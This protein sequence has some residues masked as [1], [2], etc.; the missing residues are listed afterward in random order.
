MKNI[1]ASFK[2]VTDKD[3]ENFKESSCLLTISVGQ[4]YHEGERFAATVE[5]INQHFDAC[6]ISIYDSL[7]RY[8]MALNS[9]QDPHDFHFL[10]ATEGSLWLKRNKEYLKKI[11]NLKAVYRW[12]M[13]L[14]HS[15]FVTA[16]PITHKNIENISKKA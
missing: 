6:T 13:W 10:A 3:K 2:G 5:L 9:N 11:N 16:H 8:T 1:R 12:D 15:N 14:K 4:E 7:Q